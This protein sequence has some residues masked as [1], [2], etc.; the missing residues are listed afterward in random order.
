MAT[1]H[2]ALQCLKPTS[3]DEVPQ[4]P[5]EL[6]D[7]M[8]EIFK[9]SRLVAE[10][11][12]DPPISDNDDYP[13]LDSTTNSSARRIVPSSVRV[14]ETDPE[15]TDLQKEWGKPLKMGGPRDNPLD[16][17]VWKLPAND[18]G[19][20]WFGRRSVHEGLSFSHWR[21]KLS[22]EYDETL[23]VNRKKI[24]KG[25]TP[26]KCIRGIGA[27]EK[28][29]NIEVKDHDGSILGDLIVYHVSAQFPRPT[30]PRDFVPLII[31]SDSGLQAGG[32]K[33]PGR[34]WMMISKPC[35]HPD[36]RHKQGYT[37]GQ[38]ESIELIREIPKKGYRSSSSSQES[39]KNRESPSSS[40]QR[41][42]GLPEQDGARD[43]EDEELNPVEWIMVT[44]SDPGGN[45]PRWMV[46]KGTPRS[47]GM[48]AAKFVNWALQDD[49]PP[50][51]EN[52]AGT[53]AEDTLAGAKAKSGESVDEYD[54]DQADDSDSDYESLDSD[55]EHSHHGLIA[56]VT[57][58]LS[59]GL[60]RFA[61]QVLGYGAHTTVSGDLPAGDEVS[62]I[63]GD[64]IAHL[65]PKSVQQNKAALDP[66]SSRPPEHDHFSLSS[67]NSEQ[68]A[69]AID[70]A[71]NNMSPEEL[72]EMTKD[73]KPTSHEKELAKLAIRKREVE[74]K[75]DEIRAELDKFQI[76]SQP[77]S[78][79]GTPV[80]GTSEVDSDTNG[81]RKRAATNRSSRPASTRAQ[82][83]QSQPQGA[84]SNEDLSSSAQTATPDPPSLLPKAASQFLNGESKLLKQLRKIE[85]SQLKIASK[86]Q[87][88]QR[89][90]EERS[91]KSKSKNKSEVDSLKQEV[92]D[93]KKEVKQLRSERKKWV[94]L[95]SSLQAENTR[96]AAKS[97]DA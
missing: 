33:Q 56:S 48:D 88:K 72:I 25:Q 93:L 54:S 17:T 16:V 80:K 91:Q 26:D 51:Q 21:K 81:M 62:Y 55:G 68:A 23:K 30:A 95:V 85:A 6:R 58:L 37:R 32:T 3:W 53:E 29:E 94:D 46:D 31:N 13:G 8:H 52:G 86:I 35:D 19:S 57:N 4:N 84:L 67:A 22:T 78:V 40:L 12:P 15:I 9:K 20:S 76:S 34:S 38:Y 11:L 43:D 64:G 39:E 69:T 10:S 50:K 97:E 41:S 18:G 59:T 45:I 92:H 7:Y 28:I 5:D 82:Q 27:E 70:E 42:E 63:D 83:S 24:E 61:P 96:L 47:V 71:P 1:L 2:E 66:E 65:N 14:G 73:G 90:D 89:K 79:S 60:E 74:I 49:K 44:R 87:A 77:P 36:V 75:L